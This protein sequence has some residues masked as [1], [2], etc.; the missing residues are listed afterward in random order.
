METV[1]GLGFDF[2][3]FTPANLAWAGRLAMHH[4]APFDRILVAQA[5]MEDFVPI[6]GDANVRRFDV[7][8][9]Q[10]AV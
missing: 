10:T 8:V 4:R 7:P 3:A 9:L 6:T 5:L 2:V 1:E